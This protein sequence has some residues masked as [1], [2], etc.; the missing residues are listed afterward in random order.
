MV[1][2]SPNSLCDDTVASKRKVGKVLGGYEMA[3]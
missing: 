2:D 3:A 1:T